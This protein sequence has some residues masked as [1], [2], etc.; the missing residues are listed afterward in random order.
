MKKL[1]KVALGIGL[2]V[3]VGVVAGF[4]LPASYRVE[5]SAVMRANAGAVYAQLNNFKKWPEWS[6]WT[7]ER[8]ADM[9]VSYSG[10]ETGVG[11]V[12]TWEGKTSGRGMMRI[13]GAEPDR[14][15][16]YDLDFEQGKYVSRGRLSITPE[17]D[18]LKVIWVNEGELGR[19]P[20]NRWV[21]LMMDSMMGPDFQAGLDKLKGKVE[22]TKL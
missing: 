14:W 19:N 9:K 18:Q 1:K 22:L 5:R 21:G 2:M 10:S 4:F 7:V 11:A 20:I 3:L 8:Y 16:D 17:G 12:Y 15:I 13:T 6:A